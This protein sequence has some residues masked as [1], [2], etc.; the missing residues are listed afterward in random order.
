MNVYHS[1]QSIHVI[2]MLLYDGVAAS[3]VAGPLECFGLANY[4]SGRNLYQI[5]TFTLDG[6]PVKS[7][8]AWLGLAPSCS[9]ADLPANLH[10]LLVPGGPAV[11]KVS[12]DQALTGWLADRADTVERIGSICNGTFVLA[13]AGLTKGR[14]VATH[15]MYAGELARQY[16]E[17][18]VD[19][20]ALFIRS[21]PLW[22]SGGMSAGMDLAL[23]IIE[24]DFGRTL[25]MEVAR[26]MVLYMRRAG[27]QN[28]FS[29]H[30]QSQFADIPMVE[31][32]Q[33]II[34]DDPAGDHRI[35]TL[36]KKLAMSERTM[37]RLFKE[38][39]GQTIG[40]FVIG[41]RLRSACTLLETSDREVKEIAILS[42]LGTE[43]NM[44]RTFMA[45]LN[46][47]PTEYRDRFRL[48]AEGTGP[49]QRQQLG[50]DD[51][52]LHRYEVMDFRKGSKPA[53]A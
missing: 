24:A 19:A 31:R 48:E 5:C 51:H 20:D 44:R 28:Q 11:F 1:P 23:A 39:T 14:R 21:G 6:A 3:D 46:A 22:S 30:L 41:I 35:E 47:S 33:Q 16:P 27:G 52:W 26:M 34:M 40:D 50:Y 13:A 15:W 8:G 38:A 36:A 12:Q 2:A 45:R 29:V 7:G 43:A 17:T 49:E 53:S 42:G 9:A 25:A 10:T 32:M 4:A 37:L 18:D